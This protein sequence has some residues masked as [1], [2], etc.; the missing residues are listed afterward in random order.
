MHFV[1]PQNYNFSS[2]LF[3]IFDYTTVLFNLVW[4]V[5][6]FSV[7]N[8]FFETLEIKILICTVLFLPFFIISIIGLY[9]ENIFFVL[10]YIYCFFKNRCIY[11]YSKS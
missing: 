11:F 9:H 1:F 10:S 6:L 2:R 7:S 8:I 4:F 3:G 5:F